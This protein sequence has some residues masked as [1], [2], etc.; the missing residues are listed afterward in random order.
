M[1]PD[2]EQLEDLARNYL[3]FLLSRDEKF[4][5]PFLSLNFINRQRVTS[6]LQLIKCLPSLMY[7]F[8]TEIH[9][10]EQYEPNNDE[11]S[12][13]IAPFQFMISYSTQ[14]HLLELEKATLTIHSLVYENNLWKIESIVS[15]ADKKILTT[16]SKNSAQK[17]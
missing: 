15:E 12:L 17:K 5:K 10:Y 14:M 11:G 13:K 7:G 9:L 2:R 3:S 6:E 1:L 4:I 8:D 16:M